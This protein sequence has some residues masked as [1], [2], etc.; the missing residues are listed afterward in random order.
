MRFLALLLLTLMAAGAAEPGQAAT[1]PSCIGVSVDRTEEFM[2]R[3]T[4]FARVENA[5]ARTPSR[6]CI[7]NANGLRAKTSS[8]PAMPRC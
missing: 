4:A 2:G 7:S 6:S 8:D 3:P 1:A 5:C